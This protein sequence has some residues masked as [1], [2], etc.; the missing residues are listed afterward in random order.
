M[1][2]VRTEQGVH[3]LGP[4]DAFVGV[5]GA[6]PLDATASAGAE[7]YD[8]WRIERGIPAQPNDIDEM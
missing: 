4:H 3:L 2:G 7:A 6:A 8:A 1:G 5:R